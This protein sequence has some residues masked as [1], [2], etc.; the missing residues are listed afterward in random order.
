VKLKGCS[1]TSIYTTTS[2]TAPSGQKYP[3]A[4]VLH[5]ARRRVVNRQPEKS[6]AEP[7]VPHA[8][9]SNVEVSATRGALGHLE[10]APAAYDI[11]PPH[12][13]RTQPGLRASTPS[14]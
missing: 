2:S 12:H 6:R 14:T 1:S 7:P 5:V 10:L 4:D 13:H 8:R 11:V 3:V 9:L